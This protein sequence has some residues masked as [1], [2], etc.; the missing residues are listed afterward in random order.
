MFNS[1][2]FHKGCLWQ[3]EFWCRHFL[4]LLVVN[5]W[6]LVRNV[7]LTEDMRIVVTEYFCTIFVEN[8]QEFRIVGC[9]YCSILGCAIFELQLELREMVGFEG[10]ESAN[11][12]WFDVESENILV[13][14]NHFHLLLR[15]CFFLSLPSFLTWQSSLRI[16]I[17]NL[18]EIIWIK[19][20]LSLV[21]P[22]V[23]LLFPFCWHILRPLILL[24]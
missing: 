20:E 12:L 22:L 23:K 21:F 5:G 15:F 17:W 7:H 14:F 6:L 13:S 2:I 18:H 1:E 11:E 24:H 10:G 19:L 9:H 8:S 3:V 16:E 4:L